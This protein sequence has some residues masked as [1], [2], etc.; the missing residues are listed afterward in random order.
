[1]KPARFDATTRA[2]RARRSA[3]YRSARAACL[4][5]LPAGESAVSVARAAELLGMS[6]SGA[7]KA[8]YGG[9]LPCR[10]IGRR[11]VVPV[12]ALLAF[13]HKRFSLAA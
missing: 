1:V 7:E 4:K 13:S 8:V 10:K 11:S 9:R 12:D 6:L 2:E 5:A 3:E